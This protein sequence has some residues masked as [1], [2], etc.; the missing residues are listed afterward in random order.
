M[1]SRRTPLIAQTLKKIFI[2]QQKFIYVLKSFI[3]P[4]F[5]RRHRVTS[6]LKNVETPFKNINTWYHY[7]NFR[8]EF[9]DFKFFRPKLPSGIFLDSGNVLSLRELGAYTML[10]NA[11]ITVN[12]CYRS[13]LLSFS[14]LSDMHKA[15]MASI[16]KISYLF[17]MIYMFVLQIFTRVLDVYS[18]PLYTGHT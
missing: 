17:L 8:D 2:I 1:L 14:E 9:S 10:L 5:H 4:T 16:L 12:H 13:S 3:L 7:I 18:I 15:D 6:P 11:R